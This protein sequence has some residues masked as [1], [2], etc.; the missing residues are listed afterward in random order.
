VEKSRPKMLATYVCNFQK[1]C[2]QSP[3]LVTL[4]SRGLTLGLIFYRIRGKLG[5]GLKLRHLE[6]D[7]YQDK[8]IFDLAADEINGNQK[9][10]VK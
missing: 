5:Q 2:P 3:T 4:R 8:T 6:Q 10:R 7:S 9:I 1:N